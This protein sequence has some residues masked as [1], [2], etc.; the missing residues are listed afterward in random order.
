MERGIG[1]RDK[2]KM[3]VVGVKASVAT[4]AMASEVGGVALVVVAGSSPACPCDYLRLF[5]CGEVGAAAAGVL[6]QR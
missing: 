6:W 5:C 4:M 2:W 1:K 3:V